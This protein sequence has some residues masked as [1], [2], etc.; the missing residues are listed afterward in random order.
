MKKVM[1]L[2]IGLAVIMASLFIA[3]MAVAQDTTKV[4]PS[5]QIPTGFNPVYLAF[6][7][8][9]MLAH[10][11][12]HVK[13]MPGIGWANVIKNLTLGNL[14]T[15]FG[16]KFHMTLFAT[17]AAAVMGLAETYGLNIGFAVLA[18]IPIAAAI[19]AGY[20][21]DSAFNASPTVAASS[22]T[23]SPPLTK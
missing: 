13:N 8:V 7:A 14:V 11:V 12:V 20:I 21:G 2:I 23:V 3:V 18:P 10:F 22:G 17:A 16:N 9:G 4:I 6:F 19:V 1:Q 15:W 5:I